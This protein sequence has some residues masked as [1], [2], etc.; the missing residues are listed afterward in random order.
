MSPELVYGLAG[1]QVLVVAAVLAVVLRLVGQARRE[2]AEVREALGWTCA[3]V[4]RL[5]DARGLWVE[6]GGSL[7]LWDQYARFAAWLQAFGH[8]GEVAQPDLL[9]L[10][11]IF[12]LQVGLTPDAPGV[13]NQRIKVRLV[14]LGFKPTEVRSTGTDAAGEK[15]KNRNRGVIVPEATTPHIRRKGT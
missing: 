11:N 10:Y 2:A 8:T 15:L 3:S 12:C 5:A 14:E 1:V 7:R 4:E 9:R 6:G 13:A